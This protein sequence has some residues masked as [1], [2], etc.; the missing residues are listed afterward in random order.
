M[1]MKRTLIAAAAALALTAAPVSVYA[2]SEADPVDLESVFA[3]F[4]DDAYELGDESFSETMYIVFEDAYRDM[5]SS[6]GMDASWLQSA[7]ID[8]AAADENDVTDVNILLTLN[9]TQLYHINLNVDLANMTVSAQCPELKTQPLTIDLSAVTPDLEVSGMSLSKE[10]IE[11][12]IGQ[13]MEFVASVPVETWQEELFKY[14]GI[15]MSRLQ[16]STGTTTVTLGDVSVEASTMTFGFDSTAVAEAIPE[17]LTAVTEDEVIKS[18]FESEFMDTLAGVIIRSQGGDPTGVT[19]E[20]LYE[21]IASSLSEMAVTGDFSSIPGAQ[22]TIGM[23]PEG[24]PCLAELDL[25]MSGMTVEV[26][27]GVLLTDG[28]T[29]AFQV[30]PGAMITSSLGLSEEETT[31]LQGT[32]GIEDGILHEDIQLLVNGE[33]LFALYLSDFDLAALQEGELTGTATVRFGEYEFSID[34]FTT[35]DGWNA[36]TFGLNGEPLFT[37]YISVSTGDVT[38]EKMDTSDAFPVMDE[39]SLDAYLADADLMGFIQKLTEAGVP[40]ELIDAMLSSEGEE[41]LAG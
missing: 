8:V 18:L 12:L 9:E 22:V 13:L 6:E 28:N 7:Q 35:D 17:F 26:C 5:L 19:G 31:A 2:E 3:E 11:E 15:V 27:K 34:Y 1:F 20:V 25:L 40:Q 30:E 21:G 39:D 10:E 24:I 38:V 33:P 23:D 14:S 37:E 4:G 36:M 41:Q 32:G 16:Q 29:H